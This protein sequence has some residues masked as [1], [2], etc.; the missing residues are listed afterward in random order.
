M[1]S[2]EFPAT[3]IVTLLVGL[4]LSEMSGLVYPQTWIQL[5]TQVAVASVLWVV[6]M[7][8]LVIPPN[9]K[10]RIFRFVKR[11]RF[12]PKARE[13][14]YPEQTHADDNRTNRMTIGG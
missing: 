5:M 8:L 9:D 2:C 12:A 3:V 4:F 10:R 11:L 7:F 13:C 14:H 1:F 6:L